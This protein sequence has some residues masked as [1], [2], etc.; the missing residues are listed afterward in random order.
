MA[1]QPGGVTDYLPAI[2]VP[3]L[4]ISISLNAASNIPFAGNLQQKPVSNK[5][6]PPGCKHHREIV[7][8]TQEYHLIS[9]VGQVMNLYDDHVEEC[10]LSPSIHVPC[11]KY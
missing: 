4:V 11:K 2:P 8:S 1:F 6:L 5:L 9:V 10:Y 7:F 3:G